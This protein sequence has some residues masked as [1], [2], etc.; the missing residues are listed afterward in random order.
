MD[1]TDPDIT[2]DAVGNCNHCSSFITHLATEKS[3]IAQQKNNL[4]AIISNIKSAGKNNEF[5]CIVGI[6]GGVDSCYTAYLCKDLGL[7]PLL[8]HLDNGWNSE[9]AMRNIHKIAKRLE[10]PYMSYVLDWEE[11]KQVISGNGPCNAERI[12]ARSKAE[13]EGEW[14]R[15]AA[16][17][18]AEKKN[19]KKA[20]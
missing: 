10:L 5:D 2:F 4:N 1:T 13:K 16:M 3:I 17:A 6:S 8:L 15:E 9:I 11:F 19:N 20:S 7:K 18:Y 14:V 12:A